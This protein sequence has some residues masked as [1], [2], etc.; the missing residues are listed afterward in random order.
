MS[1]LNRLPFRKLVVGSFVCVILILLSGCAS[2]PD[3]QQGEPPSI[4]IGIVTRST[5]YPEVTRNNRTYILAS[6]SRIYA[7]DIIRTDKA[8]RLILTMKDDT[9]FALGPNSHFV[10]HRYDIDGSL[11]APVAQMSFTS[12]SIRTKTARIMKAAQ[13]Q[14]EIRTPLAVI[15]VRG[16]DFWSGYLFG[17]NTLD[18]AML[19]GKGIYVQNQHGS[20]DLTLDGWGTTVI[21]N[22]APTPPKIWPSQKINRALGE[23]TL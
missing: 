9:T 6:Q 19:S 8:S 20:V 7:E 17:T 21:G 23:T 2:T 4:V 3:A 13:P 11:N 18:V 10:L 15:G 5:G 12:G 16:T 14:F 1:L 22:S